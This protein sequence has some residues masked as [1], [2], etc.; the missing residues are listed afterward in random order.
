MKPPA[1]LKS[2]LFYMGIFCCCLVVCAVLSN[3]K[4][5]ATDPISRLEALYGPNADRSN[6]TGA[7]AVKLRGEVITACNHAAQ[8]WV[9]RHV[10][11]TEEEQIVDHCGAFQD[12][13]GINLGFS[14]ASPE[15][16]TASSEEENTRNE[17]CGDHTLTIAESYVLGQGK[18]YTRYETL[19]EY[20]GD[21]LKWLNCINE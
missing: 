1:L 11:A 16:E 13:E 20:Y 12:I 17:R 5:H 3:V 15:S 19:T 4:T 18:Q 6:N 10:S 7:L 9:N 21:L 2:G 8:K 14:S